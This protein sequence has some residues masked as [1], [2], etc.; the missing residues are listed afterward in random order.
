[1]QSAIAVLQNN[2]PG[3]KNLVLG[4]TIFAPRYGESSGQELLAAVAAN[5]TLQS[6]DFGGNSLHHSKT[7][8]A[9]GPEK[10]A[11]EKLVHLL[12]INTTLAT[13]HL[14]YCNLGPTGALVLADG[15]RD[16]TGLSVLSCSRN[17]VQAKGAAALFEALKKNSKLATLNLRANH[18]S[19]DCAGPMADFLSKNITLTT[20]ELW[21]NDLGPATLVLLADVLAGNKSLRALGLRQ[22]SIGTNLGAI[23]RFAQA[24]CEPNF[25]PSLTA[26]DMRD[27]L[28]CS[29]G[30]AEISKI[31]A[32][33]STIEALDLGENALGATDIVDHDHHS[34]L[35]RRDSGVFLPILCSLPF[36]H[37][38][39]D[40]HTLYM[41][42]HSCDHHHR[43]CGWNALLSSQAEPCIQA[44][45][46]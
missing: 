36:Q 39:Y 38:Q 46:P 37:L 16:N 30:V 17:N 19:A 26:V 1:M 43:S 7:K 6:L 8:G 35:H 5:T 34:D 21:N 12:Q 20:L 31:L 29:Q 3:L 15:L 40:T 28:I 2:A 25:C 44:Q 23:S 11:M 9:A 22:N 32:H 45:M 33:N 4:K 10:E 24:F 27:N 13:L 42:A 14:D 41:V 18:I